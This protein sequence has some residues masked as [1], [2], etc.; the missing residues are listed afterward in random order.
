MGIFEQAVMSEVYAGFRKL[1]GNFHADLQGELIEK[2]PFVTGRLLAGFGVGVVG[3]APTVPPEDLEVYGVMTPRE[4]RTLAEKI[5]LGVDSTH[6]NAVE[7]AGKAF[8][9]PK[10]KG[11][12]EKAVAHAVR[13]N[14]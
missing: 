7:Y 4:A 2:T 5:P 9:V 13:S 8:N 6:N 10:N 12:F 14:S 11:T 1:R 3:V